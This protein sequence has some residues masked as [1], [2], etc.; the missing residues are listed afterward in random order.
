MLVVMN[1][2]SV[3]TRSLRSAA[4]ALSLAQRVR[5]STLCVLPILLRLSVVRRS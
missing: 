3:C 2:L 5:G 4:R 1:A